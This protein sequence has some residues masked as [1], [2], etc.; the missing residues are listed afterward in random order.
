MPRDSGIVSNGSTICTGFSINPLSRQKSARFEGLNQVAEL[1]ALILD[2]G[3]V[4]PGKRNRWLK[5]A[6]HN[7]PLFGRPLELFGIEFFEDLLA[8]YDDFESP[9][10]RM[11]TPGPDREPRSREPRQPFPESHP[12]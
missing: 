4:L 10:W 8:G 3:R 1:T 11:P 9:L 5:L 12:E 2:I 6:R 7:R